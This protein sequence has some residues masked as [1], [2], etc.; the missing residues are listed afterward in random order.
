MLGCVLQANLCSSFLELRR[1]V[2]ACLQQLVQREA[3][4]VSEYAVS[5]VKE[6]PRRDNPQLGESR[7]LHQGFLEPPSSRDRLITLLPLC[8]GHLEGGGSGRSPVHSAR[9]GV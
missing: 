9:P 7:Q 6:R 8:R 5:L 3:Q 1:A 4:E 2:V